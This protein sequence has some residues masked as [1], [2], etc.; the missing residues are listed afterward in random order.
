MILW[1][2]DLLGDLVGDDFQNQ[3]HAG[4]FLWWAKDQPR[5]PI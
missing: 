4:D 5:A 1:S 2:S 3:Q